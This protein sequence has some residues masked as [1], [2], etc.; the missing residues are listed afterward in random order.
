M[1]KTIYHITI[2]ALLL[3]LLG[4]IAFLC[5]GLRHSRQAGAAGEHLEQS[6][7]DAKSSVSS[8]TGLI[9]SGNDKL[10]DVSTGLSASR[11]TAGAIKDKASTSIERCGDIEQ[12]IKEL[13]SQLED[14]ERNCNS[15]NSDSDGLHHSLDNNAHSQVAN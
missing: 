9:E 3:S 6:I 10:T 15:S 12:T 13:R 2:V 8:A 1:S 7:V 4:N 11:D 5:A 14:L